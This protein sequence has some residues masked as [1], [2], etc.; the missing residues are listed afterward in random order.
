MPVFLPFETQLLPSEQWGGAMGYCR[1]LA[2]IVFC[3][4]LGGAHIP[5]LHGPTITSCDGHCRLGHGEK[6]VENRGVTM[7][8]FCRSKRNKNGK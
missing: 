1:L 2:P 4:G 6:K 7:S 3:I 5:L 8:N